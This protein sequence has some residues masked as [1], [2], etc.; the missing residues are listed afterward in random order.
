MTISDKK[1]TLQ[2]FDQCCNGVTI[3]DKKYT[4]QA[5]DQCCNSVTISDKYT[6]QAFDQC[7]NILLSV[8][9]SIHFRHLINAVIF[10]YQ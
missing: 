6:L 1:C 4:L 3:S 8:T 2:A 9:R 5:F 10:Y 7:C